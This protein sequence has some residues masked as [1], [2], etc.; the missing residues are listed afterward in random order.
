M[1]DLLFFRVIVVAVFSATSYFLAPFGLGSI[2]A[3]ALGACIAAL[4]VLLDARLR[5]ENAPTIAGA[6]VGALTGLLIA[7]LFAL[8]VSHIWT[9][10]TPT[11]YFVDLTVLAAGLYLG[12]RLGAEKGGAFRIQNTAVVTSNSFLALDTSVIIDGRIADIAETGFLDGQLAVPRFV[13]RELQAVA[14]SAD[15]AKRNRGRRGLDI[16]QRIQK[17]PNMDVRILEDDFP[18]IPEVDLKLLELAKR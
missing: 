2:P 9:A 17:I 5:R 7:Y 3:A 14:D 15:G 8:T 4:L 6:A 1:T 10:G 16:L 13:M 12:I 18:G 11:V